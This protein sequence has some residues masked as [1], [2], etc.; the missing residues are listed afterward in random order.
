MK[1]VLSLDGGADVEVVVRRDGGGYLVD[2]EEGGRKRTLRIERQSASVLADG[3]QREI[4]VRPLDGEPGSYQAASPSSSLRVEVA[5]PL[6]RLAA[7]SRGASG[8]K[9]GGRIAAYMPGRVISVLVEAGATV[10][11]GQGLVVLEAMKMQNEIQAER[12]GVVRRV[13][14]QAGQSVDGGDLMFEI[15]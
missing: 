1:L 6:T 3:R 4:S 5:D 12:A 9:R 11:A 14:V 13:H 7:Q 10:A 2:L 8:G 15:D